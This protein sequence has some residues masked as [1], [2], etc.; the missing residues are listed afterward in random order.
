MAPSHLQGNLV[1]LKV[2][3]NDFVKGAKPRSREGTGGH[4]MAS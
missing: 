1:D 2:P 3:D 4:F